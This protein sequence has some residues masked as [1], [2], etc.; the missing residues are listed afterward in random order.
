MSPEGVQ[1]DLTLE[2]PR[3]PVAPA[4]AR[5]AI[6]ELAP[7]LGDELSADMRLLVSELVTNSVKYGAD[8]GRVRLEVEATADRVRVEIVDEGDGFV[9]KKRGGDP[10]V[11]GGWGLHIVEEIADR[12]GVFEGSTHVWF[13]IDRR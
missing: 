10:M 11:V 8:D 13:E 9:P 5:R 3:G 2:L 6:R 4:R 1:V 12:W 7:Q